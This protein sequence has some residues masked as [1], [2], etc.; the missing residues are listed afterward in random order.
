L[1]HPPAFSGNNQDNLGDK[2]SSPQGLSGRSRASSIHA[3]RSGRDRNEMESTM[4]VEQQHIRRRDNGS[5]DID[6][7]RQVGLMERRMVMTNFARGLKKVHRGIVAAL[8]LAA[9]LYMAPS[10][11]GTGWNE[12]SVS[13]RWQGSASLDPLPSAAQLYSMWMPR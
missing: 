9:A 13:G 11:D 10:R 1:R 6:F 3:D 12:A 8:M 4:L 5:I 2:S 7:Y